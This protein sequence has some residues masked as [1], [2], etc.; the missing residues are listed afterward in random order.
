MRSCL[1]WTL[2]GV[3]M[4]ASIAVFRF[5]F[6]VYGFTGLSILFP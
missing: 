3:A 5:L 4:L 6:I 1:I 2:V